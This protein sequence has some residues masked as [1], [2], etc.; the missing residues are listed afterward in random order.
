MLDHVHN[1]GLKLYLRAFRS[2]PVKNVYVD[3]DEPSL[4]ARRAKLSLSYD[5]KI[6]S[7]LKHSIHDAVFD[8]K[9]MKLFGAR[10]NIILT[11]CLL[12][13]QF[14]TTLIFRHFG[15]TFIP[16]VTTL[17]YQT[18]NDC[19]GSDVSV[20]QH[21]AQVHLFIRCF[22]RKYKKGTV[23]I[24]IDG[25]AFPSNTVISMRLPDSASI[26]TAE[27]RAI[28]KALE[29]IKIYVASKYIV[30]TDSISCLQALQSM[31]LGHPLI[32]MVIRKCIFLNFDNKL[33]FFV[34][35]L[36]ILV[37]DVT[38]RHTP[39]ELSHA[40]VGVPYTDFLNCISVYI[41]STRQGG[42]NGAVGNKLRSLKPVLGDWQSSY[43]RCRMEEE[44]FVVS[45]SVMH[46]SF[47]DTS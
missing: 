3:A 32:G 4:G 16:C 34:G 31:E 5:S 40:K 43:K 26:F 14:L 12:I 36:A 25:S 42:W 13:I 35:Y 27:I 2:S 20:K 21:I 30:Y 18:T 37:L 44:V 8:N 33:L 15:N 28:I 10:P 47:I 22:S 23:I 38:K 46:I 41:L 45:A 9:Y 39:L 29:E 1:Q 24:Y 19:A 11:V 7:L 17:V 6:K